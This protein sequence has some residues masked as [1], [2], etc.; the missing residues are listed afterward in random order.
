MKKYIWCTII[1]LFNVQYEHK[2]V[3]VLNFTAVRMQKVKNRRLQK[4]LNV[5]GE[6]VTKWVQLYMTI[7]KCRYRS[8]KIYYWIVN[9]NC[10][11]WKRG[12]FALIGR[13]GILPD[14]VQVVQIA[15]ICPHCL[16]ARLMIWNSLCKHSHELLQCGKSAVLGY[17]YFFL[18]IKTVRFERESTGKICP[19][20]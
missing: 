14:I 4:H 6:K 19:A 16:F 18:Y 2:N 13:Q 3:K 10:N 7:L 5:F 15:V 17:L 9:E 12:Y 8:A 11:S 20:V 1:R